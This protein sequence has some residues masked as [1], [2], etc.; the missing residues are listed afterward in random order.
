MQLQRL[1][2]RLQL[3]KPVKVRLTRQLQHIIRLI[4]QR[5]LIIRSTILL[6]RIIRLRVPQP[7]GQQPGV[8][9][10]VLPQRIIHSI[11]LQQHLQLVQILRLHII[12]VIQL[13]IPR[14]LHGIQLE[15][16]LRHITRRIQRL[17]RGKQ[18]KALVLVLQQPIILV[19]QLRLRLILLG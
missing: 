3:G 8:L 11:V 6:Q 10:K 16:Q 15:A 5:L 17:Q 2:V 18:V 4:T 1:I 13:V 9:L 19:I 12:R 14:L 7:L